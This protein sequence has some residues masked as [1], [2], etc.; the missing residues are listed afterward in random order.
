MDILIR[1]GW[2]ADGTGN[3]LYPADVMIENDRIVAVENL[4]D[5]QAAHVID[6]GGKIVCP[7]F[8]DCHSHT[9]WTIHTNPTAQSTI[10]QGVTTEIV[11]NC[12]LGNAPVSD[13]SRES[14]AG[15]LREYCYEGPVIWSSFAEYLDAISQMGTSCNL[16]WYVTHGAIRESVG[17]G[18]STKSS[19]VTKEQMN[20]MK[21]S[22]REA[23]EAGALG[24]SS[25]LEYE[26][27]RLASPEELLQLVKV[28]GE[29]DGYYAS[30][31]RNYADSL[32]S[33]IEEFIDIVGLAGSRGQVSHLNVRYNTGAEEGA[34]LRAVE[35]IEQARHDGM[36]IQTDC[37]GLKDGFGCLAAILPPWIRTG[38]AEQTAKLLRDP[39]VRA[40]VRTECDRYWRFLHRGEWD[41]VRITQSKQFPEIAGKNF[42]EI[43]DLWKKDVW[44][45]YF[46]VLVAAGSGLDSLLALALVFTDDHVEEM[47]S[48][49]L[50]S[51]EGDIPSSSL[52]GPLKE[53]LPYKA[54][55]AGMIHFLTHHVKEKQTLR[56]ED[57]I[58]KM[59]SM[60]ATHFGLRDRG[61][62]KR[63]YFA[64]V[65]VFD[66]NNLDDI[67]TN[68]KP[69][70]YAKGVEHVIIN[71]T[72]VVDNAEHTATR[73]G[74]NLLRSL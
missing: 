24:F 16:A 40:R 42:F 31:I 33:G 28:V 68:E 46:D 1:N 71:G 32:Q 66:Y 41:R 36:N 51:L 59:T 26:P 63:G 60:P 52:D 49:P 22:V 74:R 69:L 5:A 13:F 27:G 39:Q 20:S 34:W 35:T 21:N 4:H 48:H 12:G 57:A 64:D 70:A 55:Y 72:I 37:V 30:H 2:I 29:Y 25:G 61:L 53:K 44:D 50:F 73:P 10:R 11:G 62:I 14:V 56:I 58:R 18:T 38:G 8:I 67:S 19:D 17:I 9:D 7:G 47:V 15:R 3:P 65:V 23:M 43:A 6:A 45:C 54:S